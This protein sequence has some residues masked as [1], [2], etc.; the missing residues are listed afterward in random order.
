MTT[1]ATEAQHVEAA[2]RQLDPAAAGLREN[3][4]EEAYGSVRASIVG[5]IK[6]HL[7]LLIDAIPDHP[8]LR[9]MR[10]VMRLLGTVNTM[11]G[12]YTHMLS[13][14]GGGNPR[15]RRKGFIAEAM[16]GPY[17]YA[18]GMDPM[19]GE[20]EGFGGPMDRETAGVRFLREAIA[21]QKKRSDEQRLSDL[22]SSLRDMK[23]ADLPETMWKPIEER[24]QAL[25][26]RIAST[27]L[28]DTGAT[29]ATASLIQAAG[30]PPAAVES[31]EG[32]PPVPSVLPAA[33][34]VAPPQPE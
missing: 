3:P 30:G 16:P 22:S 10:H 28:D 15:S 19:D 27:G 33:V 13:V 31:G 17:A 24:V 23:A 1:A 7:A 25:A 18:A 32:F 12:A 29:E 34:S 5:E 6:G 26:A 9:A 4:L 21:Q 8:D 14:M 20:T 2:A 11:I